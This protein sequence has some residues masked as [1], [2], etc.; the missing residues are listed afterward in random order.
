M[1]IKMYIK[2]LGVKTSSEEPSSGSTETTMPKSILT[3]RGEKRDSV[4][5]QVGISWSE[6][7]IR[8]IEGRNSPPNRANP[9][10]EIMV[11]RLSTLFTT[12][13]KI[14]RETS[15]LSRGIFDF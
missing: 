10:R 15:A 3:K 2:S 7:E 12:D 1:C 5:K 14:R 8:E 9:L 4:K 6:N 11:L 13:R